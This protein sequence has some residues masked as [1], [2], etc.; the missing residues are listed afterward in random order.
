M[1]KKILLICIMILLCITNV[2]TLTTDWGKYKTER[3]VLIN[4]PKGNYLLMNSVPVLFTASVNNGL[5]YYN[6]YNTN[7]LNSITGGFV[8]NYSYGFSSSFS[9]NYPMTIHDCWLDCDV[10]DGQIDFKENMMFASFPDTDLDIEWRP[11]TYTKVFSKLFTCKYPS[12][13]YTENKTISAGCRYV[14]SSDYVYSRQKLNHTDLRIVES[15]MGFNSSSIENKCLQNSINSCNCETKG[16]DGVSYCW[17]DWSIQG[18]MPINPVL[19]NNRGFLCDKTGQTIHQVCQNILGAYCN[20]DKS[21]TNLW[22][23]L[24]ACYGVVTEAYNMIIKTTTD[25]NNMDVDLENAPDSEAD[26]TNT[27]TPSDSDG[28]TSSEQSNLDKQNIIY[29]MKQD[30]GQRIIVIRNLLFL[31][32]IVFSIIVL[33]F[34]IFQIGIFIYFFTRWIP[35]VMGIIILWIKKIGGMK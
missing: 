9:N 3:A 20:P 25:G 13:S 17:I 11:Y 16:G 2:C 26:L 5:T 19:T 15:S 27:P 1:S 10:N 18:D 28:A 14:M 21:E 33:L 22:G 4:I 34:Y 7:S 23:S 12:G 8:K 29:E 35:Q 6:S 31:T 24:P 32:E 30:A